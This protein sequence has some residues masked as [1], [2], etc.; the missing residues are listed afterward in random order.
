MSEGNN[1]TLSRNVVLR[2]K[3]SKSAYYA[4]NAKHIELK[5]QRLGGSISAANKIKA[6]AN[7]LKGV[8]PVLTGVD[9]ADTKWHIHLAAHL[10]SVTVTVSPT[11]RTLDTSLIFTNPND[12]KEF[13]KAQEEI[14]IKYSEE[15]KANPKLEKA[16]FARREEKLANLEDITLPKA[17][18][19]NHNDYFIWSYC[20]VHPEVANREIDAGN[21]GKIRFFIFDDAERKRSERITYKL[22]EQ[23]AEEFFKMSG[24]EDLLKS[25]L[26]L[27]YIR[28]NVRSSVTKLDK[29]DVQK[30][31]LD[32]TMS[33]PKLF[34]EVTKDPNLELKSKIE[35]YII[36]GVL[37][38]P[39]DSSMII[40]SEN[41]DIIGKSMDDTIVFFKDPA[42][43]VTIK[44]FAE[45]YNSQPK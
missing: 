22:K 7:L 25:I 28:T 12:L 17:V 18:P 29:I 42:N 39:A 20:M 4:K 34:L 38:R 40:N 8:M 9:P 35:N 5:P 36:A 30:A 23:A 45:R 37:N 13:I 32:I 2:N 3:A 41:N 44:R 31:L 27:I 10:D 15:V 26:Q 1:T 19:A 21:S 11:G 43:N 24:K 6:Q 14:V 33:N 16:A